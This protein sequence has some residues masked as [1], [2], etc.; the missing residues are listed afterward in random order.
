MS[1][2]VADAPVSDEEIAAYR[3]SIGQSVVEGQRLDHESLRRFVA[4][5]G[6]DPLP[7]LEGVVPPLGHWAWFLEAVPPERIGPDGHPLRGGFLPPVRLPRRMFAGASVR[8]LA[9]LAV[10]AMA[11]RRSTIADVRHRAGRSGDLV[12]VDVERVIL[13]EG[14][15]RIHERQTLVYRGDGGRTASVQPAAPRPSAAPGATVVDWTPGPV[16][17][18]RFSAATFNA[19]RIHYDQDYART[20]EGYPDLVVHGVFTAAKLC[21]LAASERARLLKS[22][23]F[24]AVAPLFVSQPVLLVDKGGGDEDAL[25]ALRCDG[26]VAMTATARV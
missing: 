3:G 13:Q 22:F 1:A 15:E 8:F 14:E 4:A 11:E 19:H 21:A 7:V 5:V 2:S 6:G 25:E 24:R 12:F 17:L 23:E 9:P 20:V 18:F 26:V 10:E 16:D